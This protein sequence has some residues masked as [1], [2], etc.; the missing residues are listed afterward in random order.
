[1]F[2]VTIQDELPSFDAFVEYFF[3]YWHGLTSTNNYKTYK[4]LESCNFFYKL[5]L[6]SNDLLINVF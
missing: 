4:I 5:S 2:M 3:N 1:M 6:I